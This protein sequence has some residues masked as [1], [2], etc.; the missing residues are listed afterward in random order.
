MG[1]RS[2]TVIGAG[3]AGL[4]VARALAMRGSRVTVLEQAPEIREVG[5]GAALDGLAD[6]DSATLARRCVLARRG[7]GFL[8]LIPAHALRT[9]VAG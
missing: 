9:D 1:T 3:I 4:A 7:Q 6:A 5:A 2:I 8:L